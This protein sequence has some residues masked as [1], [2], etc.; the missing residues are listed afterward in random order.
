MGKTEIMIAN[1]P[2]RFAL[3]RLIFEELRDC[4]ERIAFDDQSLL[5]GSGFTLSALRF[6]FL[7]HLGLSSYCTKLVPEPGIGPGRLVRARGCKPRLSASSSTRGPQ[8]RGPLSAALRYL[9]NTSKRYFIVSNPIPFVEHAAILFF[10]SLNFIG[11]SEAIKNFINTRHRGREARQIIA[12]AHEALPNIL[13]RKALS[14]GPQ[15]SADSVGQPEFCNVFRVYR[16]ARQ[17]REVFKHF[18][19][20]R[21]AIPN[22]H[23]VIFKFGA[24]RDKVL[25]L[26]K[27]HA[28]CLAVI[29]C[30]HNQEII[31]V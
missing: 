17:R 8:A 13:R 12:F 5:L 18:L 23:Q 22:F 1:I 9:A 14:F 19:K 2:I 26:F 6:W 10:F 7:W 31:Y 25:T 27:N 4:L 15:Y 20:M 24:A 21:D 11:G 29:R 3:A 30:F 28:P 16:Y